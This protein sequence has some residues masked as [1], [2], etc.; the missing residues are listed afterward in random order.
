VEAA[1]D[2]GGAVGLF[3]HGVVDRLLRRPGKV[4]FIQVRS[5]WLPS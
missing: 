5:G 3:H 1:L 4:L 2:H